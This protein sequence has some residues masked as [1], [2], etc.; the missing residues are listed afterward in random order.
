MSQFKP[1]RTGKVPDEPGAA[2][3]AEQLSDAKGNLSSNGSSNKMDEDE[4]LSSLREVIAAG[5]HHLDVLLGTIT[6]LARQLTGASAA[7]LAMWKEGSMV[8]RARSGETAPALGAR[9]SANTGI[10]GACLRTGKI[11]HCVDTDNDPIVD[12]EVCRN[13]GLRSIAVLPIQGWRAVNGIL[14]VF[15]PEPAAFTQTHITLLQHLAALAE[16]ARASRPNDAVVSAPKPA[17]AIGAATPSGILPA[18]DRVGDVVLAF[19]GSGRRSGSLVLGLV[20]LLAISLLGFVI[21][22]GWR[23]ADATDAKVPAVQRPASELN[24]DVGTAQSPAA[25]APSSTP[26]PAP[27]SR[28]LDNDPVWKKNPGGE[29]LFASD[30]KPAGGTPVKFASKVDKV[31]GTQAPPARAPLLANMADEVASDVTVKHFAPSHAAPEMHPSDSAPIEAPAISVG[32]ANPA[33]LGAV[34]SANLPR[35]AAPVS[36]GVSGGQLVRRVAPLYP[37]QALTLHQEGRV[38]IA[39][40]VME[41]GAVHEVK[42]VEGPKIL[43]D[44]AVEAV[45]QWRYKPFQLDGKPVKNEVRINVDFKFPQSH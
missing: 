6:D 9:L 14:E 44:A 34:L 1:I 28:P 13:L 40:T 10:S 20:G 27:N 11:Q 15:S 38:V 7:A 22:L 29:P 19:A 31:V 36:M 23:G 41:D 21:W 37:A 33:P 42:V 24:I 39:A 25:P 43:G 35:P 30:R 17:S 45:K 2:S 8:C 12:A 4:S 3:R 32:A 26:G 18:S 16:Q 5:D